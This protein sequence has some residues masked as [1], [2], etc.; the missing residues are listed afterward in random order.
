[1]MKS[2]WRRV[3][4][5][6]PCTQ[7]GRGDWCVRSETAIIC[8]RVQEGS[9]KPVKTGA[10]IGYLHRLKADVSPRSTICRKP[11]PVAQPGEPIA[12]GPILA[13]FRTPP[14]DLRRFAD[15]LG[16]TVESLERLGCVWAE[17]HGA[18]AFPMRDAD[19]EVVGVRLRSPGGRKW[20]IKGSKGGI[21]LPD[22]GMPDQAERVFVVEGPSDCAAALDI[23]LV[24]VGRASCSA[25]G[26]DLARLLCRRDVVI[27][28]D[29]DETKTA[30]DGRTFRP[31]Y[32]GAYGLA[33]R[34]L[35]KPAART[36]RVIFPLR[37]KDVREWKANG[38]TAAV[39]GMLA[40]NARPI[41]QRD[42]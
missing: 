12:W 8:M 22:G 26:D 10:G 5:R 4:R 1:M 40:Q 11:A 21:F 9:V 19:G 17:E 29:N 24:A 42:K 6:E 2:N 27:I 23:G 18:W 38:A 36:V 33:Q 16:V 32:D 30:P 35:Q 34:L 13:R 39:I 15:Q 37:G 31:G 14:G 41:T 3:T 25:G 28:G 7:C 20:A